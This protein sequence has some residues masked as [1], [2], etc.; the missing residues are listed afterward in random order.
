MSGD[1]GYVPNELLGRLVGRSIVAVH[2]VTYYLDLQFDGPVGEQPSLVCEELPVVVEAGVRLREDQPGYADSL[3]K[4]IGQFV[5]ATEERTGLGLTLTFTA[6]TTLVIHPTREQL[7]GPEIA[8][9]NGFLDRQWMCWRPGEES[10]ED[11]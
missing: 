10:F 8:H 11:L 7:L 2:F 5:V 6:G 4:L 3:R 1:E 9:L